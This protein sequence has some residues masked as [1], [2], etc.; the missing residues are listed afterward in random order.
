M[1]HAGNHLIMRPILHAFG[2][3]VHLAS[4]LLCLAA[5]SV[6]DYFVLPDSGDADVPIADWITSLGGPDLEFSGSGTSIA[7]APNGDLVLV[8]W[9]GGT[10]QL[11]GAP[12]SSNGIDDIW[13]ARYRADGKHVWSIGIG[14][15]GVDR[16]NAVAVDSAG[17]VYVAG[18]YAGPVNFGGGERTGSGEFLVKLS[19]ENGAYVW[20]RTFGAFNGSAGF[21]TELGVGVA[22]IDPQTIVIAGMF[23][24]TVDFGG[25]GWTST[26]SNGCDCV[27]AA[28]DASTGTHLWSKPLAS[29]GDECDF[30]LI[31][32]TP[33][34]CNVVGIGGDV[35]ATG[36]FAGTAALGS[37]NRASSGSSDIFIAR[38]RGNDGGH[39]WSMRYGGT[40]QERAYALATD[41]TRVLVG[42]IFY[43]TTN[44]GGPDLTAPG[45]L[46][47]FVAAYS[48]STG[49][50]VW[51]QRFGGSEIGTIAAS[52]NQ[53]AFSLPF[54]T[55]IQIG[56][57]T[58][59]ADTRNGPNPD[60]AIVRLDPANGEPSRAWQFGSPGFDQMSLTYAG[61][62][63][64]GNG[65]FGDV[66]NL[67]GTPLR[68]AGIQDIAVFRVDLDRVR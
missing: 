13:V 48:A 29:T 7:T 43:D 19:G 51:S 36:G 49:T 41:G 63:L 25:G 38:F 52:S 12:I 39:V 27:L 53:L 68:S 32:P 54:S 40:S 3:C 1:L 10:T 58:F 65:S 50:H 20:D 30:T 45:L 33:L 47:A 8:G 16:A 62:Q 59:T 17:D 37:G 4:S 67:F 46:N 21:Q 11:G 22:A 42:G 23:T 5:C 56:T 57:Q 44:L 15:T 64:A 35:I 60:I 55:T 24:G 18:S 2:V 28:Y 34:R 9:F 66:A 14:G 6:H 26:P 61:P 31:P